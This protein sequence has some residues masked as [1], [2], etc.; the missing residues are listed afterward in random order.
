MGW[1]FLYLM[2]GM[3]FGHNYQTIA[4]YLN[5]KLPLASLVLLL[6]YIGYVYIKRYSK[7]KVKNI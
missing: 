3:F 5:S 2:V 4:R 6:L 1:G 7:N